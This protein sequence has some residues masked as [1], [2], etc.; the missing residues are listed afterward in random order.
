[1]LGIQPI[2]SL[3]KCSGHIARI[4]ETTT[5]NIASR[6]ARFRSLAT[7]SARFKRTSAVERLA[8]LMLLRYECHYTHR[9]TR[10][11][12][13]FHRERDQCEANRRK[14]VEI[15]QVFEACHI[16]GTRDSMHREVF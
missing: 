8:D 1:M 6:N 3:W 10:A 2:R 7:S 5:R 13:N 4:V 16:A 9:A 12:L 15:R 11:T 14:L